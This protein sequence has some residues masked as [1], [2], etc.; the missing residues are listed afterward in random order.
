MVLLGDVGNGNLVSICFET[1]LA[2]VQ[3]WCTVCIEC[4]VGSEIVLEASDETAR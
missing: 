3:E 4:T 1:L 2:L